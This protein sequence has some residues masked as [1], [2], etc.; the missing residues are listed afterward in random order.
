MAT[1]TLRLPSSSSSFSIPP[2]MITF[3]SLPPPP[4]SLPCNSLSPSVLHLILLDLSLTIPFSSSHRSPPY[5]SFSLLSLPLLFIPPL[6]SPFH[7]PP[8]LPR[9]LP[10]CSLSPS[11]SASFSSPLHSPFP[12]SLPSFFLSILHLLL[13]HSSLSIPFPFP[14]IPLLLLLLLPF[15]PVVASRRDLCILAARRP[16]RQDW[17]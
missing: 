1:A 6:L 17:G 9:Y 3:L 11:S 8:L 13:L 5:S 2:F 15:L 10:L 12:R 7:L 14:S 16:P 4:R